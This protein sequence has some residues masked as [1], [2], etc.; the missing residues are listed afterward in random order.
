[1]TRMMTRIKSEIIEAEREGL[2]LIEH[3]IMLLDHSRE[4]AKDNAMLWEREREIRLDYENLCAG[5]ICP[6]CGFEPIKVGHSAEFPKFTDADIRRTHNI[7]DQQD[8]IEE[9]GGNLAGYIARYEGHG[10]DGA[11]IYAADL[12]RCASIVAGK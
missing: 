2:P 4:V 10:L 11:A 1:M 9:H 12:A 3:L 8:W 5:L 7:A 6:T